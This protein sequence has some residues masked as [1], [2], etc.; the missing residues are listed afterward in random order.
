M[1]EI[2]D[3]KPSNTAVERERIWTEV[4]DRLAS[5]TMAHRASAQVD[6]G[7]GVSLLLELHRLAQLVSAELPAQKRS[8]VLALAIDL[9]ARVQQ[10]MPDLY[11]LLP[12]IQT[13]PYIRLL[14]AT[15]TDPITHDVMNSA[16]L[17]R[18]AIEGGAHQGAVID[19][20]G[21]QAMDVLAYGVRRAFA[22]KPDVGISVT[23]IGLISGRMHTALLTL[24]AERLT[25]ND[26][27]AG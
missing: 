3:L 14:D 13:G 25:S 18:A 11:G 19:L 12:T 2:C 10:H 16:R 9:L 6:D 15:D 21:D 4:H 5:L 23:D 22:H 1:C 26:L 17:V 7:D 27:Y 24:L 20:A 8:L